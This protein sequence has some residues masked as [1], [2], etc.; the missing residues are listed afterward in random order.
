V[1]EIHFGYCVPIFA[2][3]GAALF[4]TP[5]Y[6]ALDTA[7]T[8]RLARMAD[9][10]GYDALWVADHLML[11]RDHA[12]LEGWT[13]LAALA[14]ST[15]RAKLGMIHQAHPFRHPALSAKMAATLD[16][17]SGGRLIHFVD[18]GRRR[19]EYIAYGL[20]WDDDIDARIARMVDGITVTLALWTADG[21]VDYAGAY[22]RLEGAVCTPRPVQR[23]HPPL[24]LGEVDPAILRA[25]A[26]H[27]QGWNTVAVPLPE[28][29][30]R[31]HTLAVACAEIGRPVEEIEKSLETQVLVAPD[32][33][34]LRRRLRE[35]VDLTPAAQRVEPDLQAF[36]QGETE[37]IPS[38]LTSVWLVGTPDS[39]EQQLRAYVREGISH[40]MLWFI[41]VPRDDG[42][43]L[44]AEQVIPR[45]RE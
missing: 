34:A 16:Q 44:F 23:P 3:P 15:E 40:F 4:R 19:D 14:G 1:R 35:M 29:R 26:R 6:A 45:F 41:D 21:P 42:M 22:Y 38:S 25:C 33:P 17:I 13:V 18:C 28:L 12:I 24:W 31:V 20:P 27:A 10:L 5:H 30:R 32:A 2:C 43:R 9:G 37:Q 7:T 39:V 36:I 8:M 11:G